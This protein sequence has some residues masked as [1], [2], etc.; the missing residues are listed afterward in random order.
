VTIDVDS[1]ICE[2]HATTRA[3][4]PTATPDSSATTR[5]WPPAPIPARC[6]ISACAR[7][8]PTPPAGAEW[9]VNELAGRV[10]RAG[11]AGELALRADSGF[12]SAK[13]MTACRRHRIRFSIT[14]RQ[15]RQV[16]AAIAAIPEA[17]WTDIDYP[18]GGIAQVAETTLA[19]ERLVVRRPR[20]VGPQA[21]LWPDWRH[22][23]FV[24]DRAG[25]AVELDADHRRHAVCELAIRDLKDGAGLR[26]CPRAASWPTPPGP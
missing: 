4:P 1:T 3:A 23:A 25:C 22:H 2:V 24:T 26:H 20:L 11:A 9:F 12:W 15:T 7:A 6:S 10:R 19:D 14:V 8:R 13:V 5:C 18:D 21:T 16:Q 17:A